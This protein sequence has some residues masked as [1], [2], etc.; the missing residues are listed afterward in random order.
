MAP[1]YLNRSV[2]SGGYRPN[3][4]LEL[5]IIDPRL[6]CSKFVYLPC[7]ILIDNRNIAKIQFQLE[8][9]LQEPPLCDTSG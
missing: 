3:Y 5:H 7:N 2:F 8:W 4:Y 9:Y 6:L 1:I